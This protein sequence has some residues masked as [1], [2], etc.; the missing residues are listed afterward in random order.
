M[1][2]EEKRAKNAEANRRWRA[3]NPAGQREAN[4]RWRE[5]HPDQA[6]ALH[7]E[8]RKQHPEVWAK[9]KKR[10]YAQTQ[11]KANTRKLWTGAEEKL[12]LEWQGTDRE[13]SDKLQRSVQAIQVRRAKLRTGNW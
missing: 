4:R 8:W 9:Q 3:T 6:K 11:G 5:S 2:P 1:T 10:N 7:K 12:V 13:L